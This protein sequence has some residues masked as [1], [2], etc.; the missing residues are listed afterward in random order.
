MGWNYT[1]GTNCHLPQAFDDLSY[2]FPGQIATVLIAST[3]NRAGIYPIEHFFI[4]KGQYPFLQAPSN[5]QFTC[6]IVT[7][8]RESVTGRT[9]RKKQAI[10]RPANTTL[11]T[12]HT[13]FA[14][15][16][17]DVHVFSFY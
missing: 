5:H 11:K 12:S 6:R 17:Q 1:P 2:M 8:E 9:R 7:L 13:P 10:K 3:T 16:I 4:L 14:Y 15:Y